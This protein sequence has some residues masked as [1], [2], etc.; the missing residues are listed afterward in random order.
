MN[1]LGMNAPCYL[2]KQNLFDI[3]LAMLNKNIL[4]IISY[5]VNV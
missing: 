3:D 1:A 5:I 2:G 4:Y